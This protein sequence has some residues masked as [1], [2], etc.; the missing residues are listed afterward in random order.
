MLRTQV[1][2]DPTTRAALVA[3]YNAA[4][5]PETRTRLQM[6]LLARDHDL[7]PAEVGRLVHR[8]HDVVLR[9]LR[10]FGEGGVAAVPRRRPKG[11]APLVTPA[12]EAELGRVIELDPRAAGV[13]SANWTTRLLAG[14]LAAQTGVAVDQE[15]VR[16]R[17]HRLGYVCKRPTWTLAER[18]QAQEGWEGNA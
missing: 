1:T 3:A 5:D 13:A 15:T 6:V 10:R 16:K 14:Y 8:S 18:A 12:W 7:S 11:R 2:F 17:L 4:P 9:V